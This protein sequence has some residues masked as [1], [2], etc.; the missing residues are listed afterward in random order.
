M[1][2]VRP[3]DYRAQLVFWQSALASGNPTAIATSARAL[4]EAKSRVDTVLPFH[5]LRLHVPRPVGD[6]WDRSRSRHPA[7][8]PRKDV[9]MAARIGRPKATPH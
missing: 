9:G 1:A 7:T 4:A 8:D 5:R 6:G 2:V 3:Q